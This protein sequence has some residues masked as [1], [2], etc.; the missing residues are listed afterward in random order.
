MATLKILGG[1]FKGLS[2]Q[3]PTGNK[4]R[5]TQA[6]LRQ[7]V[8]NISQQEVE[9]SHFLDLFAGSGAMGLEALSRQ[10]KRAVFV[11]KD[12]SAA[13]CIRANIKALHV[14]QLAE[15][16]VRDHLTALK[17]LAKRNLSFEIIYIDP[18]Y[19]KGSSMIQELFTFLENHSLIAPGARLFLEESS[20]GEEFQLT[21]SRLR[22]KDSRCF[23]AARLLQWIND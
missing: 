19:A 15:L 4:T 2:L 9:G 1:E 12:P 20:Q 7:A 14:E 21:D 18:P 11:E 13:K 10:A 17:E 3:S 6:I 22:K 16:L 23:G 8:F 5:P